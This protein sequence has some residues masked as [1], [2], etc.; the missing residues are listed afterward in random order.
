M[1]WLYLTAVSYLSMMDMLQSILDDKTG[2][3]FG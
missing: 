3:Y 1:T 2:E